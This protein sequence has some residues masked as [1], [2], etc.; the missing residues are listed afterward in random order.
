MSQTIEKIKPSY[1][2]FRDED[3]KESLTNKQVMFEEKVAQEKIDEVFQWTTS[4]EYKDLNFSR[5]ALTIN[6]A[7]ACQPLGPMSTAARAASP[8]SAPTST[9]TSRS[10]SPAFRTP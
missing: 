7:K 10:R 1:P 6:P 2:L 4:V 3:Y 8:I 5:E 9:A